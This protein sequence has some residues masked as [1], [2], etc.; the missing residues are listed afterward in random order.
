MDKKV[1]AVTGAYRGIGYSIIESF[2]QNFAKNKIMILTSRKREEGLT[3]LEKLKKEYPL[4]KENLFYHHLDVSHGESVQKF[5]NSIQKDFGHLNVLYNNA[6]ILHRNP[7]LERRDS[8]V[9]EIF[10]TNVWGLI[11]MTEDALRIMK[12]GSHIINI[13]SR[14]GQLRFSKKLQ[15]RFLEENLHVDDLHK[16]YREYRQAYVKNELEREGW[17]DKLHHYGCYGVSKVFVNAYTRILDRRFKKNKVNI[18]VNSVC[19]GW[20]RTEMGGKDAPRDSTKG[21]ETPVWLESFSDRYDESLS[22]NF[23]ADKKIITWL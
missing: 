18:K 5:I 19:P 2:C 4:A 10:N 7:P 11:N 1:I 3:A 15:E 13:S 20:C 12:P 8:E 17:D 16:L 21:A 14:L 22:G 6:A 23:Y 9:V